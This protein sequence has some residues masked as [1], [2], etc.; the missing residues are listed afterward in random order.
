VAAT[1][2]LS[3]TYS[4]SPDGSGSMA[5]TVHGADFQAVDFVLNSVVRSTAGSFQFLITTSTVDQVGMGTA[6]FQ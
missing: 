4:V 1:R 6:V 5:F 3:G 2:A